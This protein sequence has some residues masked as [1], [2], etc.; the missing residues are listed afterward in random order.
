M[1]DL[2]TPR[3]TARARTDTRHRSLLAAVLLVAPSAV[4]RPATAQEPA[5]TVHHFGVRGAGGYETNPRFVVDGG[6]S[7][8]AQF[9]LDGDLRR[10]SARSTVAVVASG[11]A[12]RYD[13]ATT[14][15]HYG[16]L[17]GADVAHLITARVA[18]RASARF[19]SSL[20]HGANADAS[21]LFLLPLTLTRSREASAAISYRVAPRVA[22]DVGA[23][24]DDVRFANP[25]LMGGSL[26][27]THAALTRRYTTTDDVGLRYSFDRN[28]LSGGTLDSHGFSGS[29]QHVHAH[30]TLRLTAGAA[31]LGA[32]DRSAATWRA[33]GDA[34]VSQR[35][36]AGI[37]A[38]RYAR[39]VSQLYGLG[40]VL[41]SDIAGVDYGIVSR[42]GS[43]FLLEMHRGW[44]A[45]PAAG[46]I[47]GRRV[48]SSGSSLL[49]ARPLA[50]AVALEARLFV[51]RNNATV[52]IPTSGAVLGLTYGF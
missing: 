20:S 17:F 19:V 8:S 36:G 11:T 1:R 43:R 23:S 29:W 14:M 2:T 48:T 31:R 3:A 13:R 26:L 50:R 5:R 16:Y 40:G 34:M 45:E 27:A 35:A 15:D 37:V 10:E 46:T 38:I 25:Q 33:I 12:T 21:G 4:A 28:S 42:R 9:G 52:T 22:L 44:F 24:H 18:A 30:G 32:S 7:V 6:G 47:L 51:A 39:S 41:A 49:L